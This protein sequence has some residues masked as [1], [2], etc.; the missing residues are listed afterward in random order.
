MYHNAIDLPKMR[1]M[2]NN[3]AK[4]CTRSESSPTHVQCVSRE[5]AGSTLDRAEDTDKK[6]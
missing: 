2:H 4:Q 6:S 3:Y 5:E 1:K